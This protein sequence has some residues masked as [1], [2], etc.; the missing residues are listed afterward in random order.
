M[1][2][3]S[4]TCDSIR[5]WESLTA[6]P[7]GKC[8]SSGFRLQHR[9]LQFCELISVPVP[10]CLPLVSHQLAVIQGLRNYHTLCHADQMPHWW[11][12][13]KIEIEWKRTLA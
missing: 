8:I 6:I 1:L 7:L 3:Y 9:N 13:D 5:N 12:A 2:S 4:W 11:S 10:M